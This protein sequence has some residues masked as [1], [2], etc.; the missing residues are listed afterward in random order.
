MSIRR[1][2]T[3]M[4]ILLLAS[5]CIL[6]AADV[7]LAQTGF[8]FLSVATDARAAAMGEAMTTIQGNPSALFFNPAG[9]SRVSSFIDINLS[10][11]Q[12]I[13]DI[14]YNSFSGAFTPASGRYGVF[15]ISLISV[16]YGEIQGTMV[17]NNERGYVDTEIFNPTALSIGFGYARA[18]SEQFSVGGQIKRAYQ[19]LGKS[20]VPEND[21]LDVV[22]KNYANALA[23]D[24]GTIYVTQWK[25]FAFGMS[26]RNFSEE[27]K[28]YSEGFQLPLNFKIGMS[29]D[30]L[31][32]LKNKPA[33][34]SLLMSLDVS[35]PRSNPEQINLGFEY[36]LAEILALRG[37]YL[38]NYDQRGITAGFG[39]KKELSG[40]LVGIDYAYTPFGV[41]DNVQRLSFRLTF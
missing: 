30:L 24:F 35:H 13:A 27:I 7:K 40:T 33:R 12:W 29:I 39:I 37:G 2:K 16:D 10:Q 18:L 14:N 1:N 17:S 5:F 6:S 34:Q 31:N 38:H 36:S 8:Q 26:V 11:N 20:V 28:Y 15:G 4:V 25:G 9:L 22:V 23:F 32:F 3:I 41:F 21:S 19:Y